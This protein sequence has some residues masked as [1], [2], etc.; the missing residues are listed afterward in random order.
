[1]VRQCTDLSELRACRQMITKEMELVRIMNYSLDR[2]L[3][4]F[5]PSSIEIQGLSSCADPGQSQVHSEVNRRA[6][7]STAERQVRQFR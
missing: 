2:Y 3:F 1:M 5:P 7:S 6:N 4:N